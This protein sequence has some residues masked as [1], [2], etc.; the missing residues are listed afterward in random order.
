MRVTVEQA[1]LARAL[2]QTTR[3]VA[4]QN[5]LPVLSGVELTAQGQSLHLYATDLTTALEADVPAEVS[6][7][8]HIV[9]PAGTLTDLIQRLPTAL[10]DI[11]AETSAQ[12]V[13]RYGRNQATIHGFAE[14]RLPEFAHLPRNAAV[15]V[16]IPGHVLA[17]V[18][19]QVLFACAR[20]EARPILKG[21]AM[22]LGEGRLVFAAT[23]GSRLS[24]VWYAV[25]DHLEAPRQW[26]WPAKAVTEASRLT[27]GLDTVT[28]WMSPHVV[29]LETA[30]FRL[31]SRLLEGQY[32]EYQ[33]VIPQQYVAEC[34][35][36]L[37]ALRG[38]VERVN[39][40]AQKDRSASL[41]IVH[42][43]GMLE[44]GTVSQDIG[45]AR[46]VVECQSTG[47]PLDLLFNPHFI[48]DVLKSLSSAE[49]VVEF[50]GTQSPARFREVGGSTYQHILLP[51]RQLV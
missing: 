49:I 18:A 25:P 40:I 2:S 3:V 8:G 4:P 6:E 26:V 50:A 20:D 36:E 17:E 14:D 28:L 24:Q 37:S 38:A 11:A 27:A 44:L 35:V 1:S 5:T 43:P 30:G 19:R 23:D 47:Q 13:I 33:R 46:E 7:P 51:L 16:T 32:P 41:R 12:A 15:A 22:E 39:L 29:Q 45:H 9:L 42:E 21:V 34:R 48:A 10:V 31:T